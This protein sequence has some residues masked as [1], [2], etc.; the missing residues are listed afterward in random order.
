[1]SS[2]TA[3]VPGRDLLSALPSDLLGEVA[4]LLLLDATALASLWSCSRALRA[5]KPAV[6]QRVFGPASAMSALFL[7]V[8]PLSRESL[9]RPEHALVL[10]ELLVLAPPP[11]L[12]LFT[13]DVLHHLVHALR[14][15]SV[16]REKKKKKKKKTKKKALPPKPAPEVLRR[17]YRDLVLG[18]GSIVSDLLG[19]STTGGD[20]TMRRV[21]RAISALVSNATIPL[22][23]IEYFY[24][25][26][27]FL[28]VCLKSEDAQQHSAACV[29]FTSLTDDG[30]DD[31]IQSVLDTGVLPRVVELLGSTDEIVQAAALR[32][33]GNI[34]A[35]GSRDQS[36]QVLNANVL[37]KLY[38]MLKHENKGII[39]ETCWLISNIAAESE[40]EIQLL[41][42]LNFFSQLIHIL[43]TE[44]CLPIRKEITW[45]IRNATDGGTFEQVRSIA[46]MGVFPPLI[47][48]L[49]IQHEN[50]TMETEGDIVFVRV[51]LEAITNLLSQGGQSEYE[52]V[53]KTSV[54]HL[55]ISCGGVSE[56]LRWRNHKSCSV[57]NS[58]KRICE[59]IPGGDISMDNVGNVTNT[60]TS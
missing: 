30:D 57:V 23:G 43:A 47:Q 24:P 40:H 31:C 3:S 10:A 21:A 48:L 19:Y 33:V 9:R 35:G 46:Y 45:A 18:N 53:G 26:L 60:T 39:K 51:V 2:S 52:G 5:E 25:A 20:D 38:P 50:Q 37:P 14:S 36:Q 17:E 54:Q 7:R 58:V 27:P 8:L 41:I 49:Q 4:R 44:D 29:A 55:L 15:V 32:T 56:I 11:P 22:V 59:L 28:T 13:D 34:A 1:M 42:D 12:Q 16:S 6:L